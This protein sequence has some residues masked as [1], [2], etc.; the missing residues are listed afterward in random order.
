VSSVPRHLS[1]DGVDPGD[2]SI[3]DAM[4]LMTTL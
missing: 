1:R 4:D 2:A 3:V